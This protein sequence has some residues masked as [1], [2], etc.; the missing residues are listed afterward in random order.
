MEQPE[1]QRSCITS[2]IVP[3]AMFTGLV[4]G[5]YLAS[6]FGLWWIPVGAVAGVVLS[7]PITGILLLTLAGIGSLGEK[8]ISIFQ[9]R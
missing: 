2:C 9:K 1:Q 6:R 8:V 4:W 7:I 3:L 5:G